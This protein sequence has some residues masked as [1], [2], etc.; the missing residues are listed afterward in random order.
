MTQAEQAFVQQL[1]R[2][3]PGEPAFVAALR[4]AGRDTFQRVKLPTLRHEDW[5]Y[6]NLAPL[7]A[8]PFVLAG[9]AR[10]GTTELPPAPRA[11]F[12]N[13]RLDRA[14]TDV[15]GLPSGVRVGSLA[16]ALRERPAALEPLLGRVVVPP[17]DHAFAA[18]N[19]GLFEDGALVEVEDGV[20]CDATLN[21]VFV[22]TAGEPAAVHP[23][24]LLVVGKGARATVVETYRGDGPY[25]VNALTELALGE[26]ARVEHD[27]V[28]EDAPGAFH[29][30]LLLVS[31]GAGSRLTGQS[32]AL[33]GLLARVETR[34]LLGAEEAA[35]DLHGLYVGAGSQV[36]DHFVHVDHA[37]PRC[38][39]REVFKGILDGSSRGVFSGRVHVREG[40][41]KSDAGQVNSNLLLSDDATVDTKPQLEILNDDVKASH[42]GSV[43]QLREDQLFYLRSRG[44][45]AAHARALLTWA[46]ASDMVERVGPE[47]LRSRVRRAVAARLPHGQ[48]LREVA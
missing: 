41:R 46:F 15:G 48:L 20:A 22:T 29:V 32:I 36:L 9:P 40:A 21:L 45:S 43:G 4:A 10:P 44:L 19:A 6:T 8:Q 34:T 14:A 16:A 12:V 1:E 27:R 47:E 31:Q 17:R 5:R 37:S 42:G 39:S 38:V 35:C 24:N 2:G 7:A 33:G 25:L 13:G 28:Q 23:R 11:V 26:G 30:G 3:R 18:L